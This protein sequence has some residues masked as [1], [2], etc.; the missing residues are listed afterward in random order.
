M[1]NFN[2]HVAKERHTKISILPIY[3]ETLSNSNCRWGPRK[4]FSFCLTSFKFKAI[5]DQF[6]CVFGSNSPK[7]NSTMQIRGIKLRWNVVSFSLNCYD[8]I[9]VN[10][11]SILESL[12]AKLCQNSFMPDGR[13][14]VDILLTVVTVH[15]TQLMSLISFSLSFFLQVKSLKSASDILTV[16]VILW[17]VSLKQKTNTH[18]R[19]L[20]ERCSLLWKRD[21]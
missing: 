13:K 16:C 20:G 7:R 6:M 10:L 5:L 14:Q 21:W 11:G 8:V 3:E 15:L 1:Q 4:F 12:C 2:C 17:V 18:S 9:L 19:T